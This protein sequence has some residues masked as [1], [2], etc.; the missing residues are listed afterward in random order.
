MRPPCVRDEH[1]EPKDCRKIARS[2]HDLG[3]GLDLDPPARIEQ[4]LDDDQCRRWVDL[5]KELAMSAAHRVP[6]GGVG[7]EHACPDD[8]FAGTAQRQ[9][10]L[11]NDL[12]TPRGLLVR[13]TENRLTVGIDGGSARDGNVRAPP[14]SPREPHQAFVG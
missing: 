1:N 14:N 4:P 6:V 8:I 10:G 5:T 3:V 13:P 2:D 7:D 11:E 12:E 9:D